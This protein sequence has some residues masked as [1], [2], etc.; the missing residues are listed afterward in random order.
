[1]DLRLLGRVTLVRLVQSANASGPMEVTGNPSIVF[2]MIKSP[3][4][5]GSQPVIVSVP[6]SSLYFIGHFEIVDPVG[7]E[8]TTKRL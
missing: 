5:L 4:G 6:F 2:G 7:F 1:M 3:V 8:P